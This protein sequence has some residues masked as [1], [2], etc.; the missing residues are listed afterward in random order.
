M[1]LQIKNNNMK[2]INNIKDKIL[3]NKNLWIKIYQIKK[4]KFKLKSQNLK[5]LIH[6]FKFKQI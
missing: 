2:L 3:F 6:L 1:K 4:N 5:F